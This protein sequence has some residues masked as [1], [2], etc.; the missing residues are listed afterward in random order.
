ND[1]K[2]KVSAIKNIPD[3]NIKLITISAKNKN[4]LKR[5]IV[6]L[7]NLSKKIDCSQLEN[8]SNSETRNGKQEWRASFT[9][10]HPGELE[11]QSS[12]LIKKLKENY[13]FD[14]S[15]SSGFSEIKI[16]SEEKA[17]IMFPGQGSQY[18]GMA[19]SLLEAFPEL[20]EYA[21]KLN[22]SIKEIIPEGVLHLIS[23]HGWKKSDEELSKLQ[24]EITQTKYAQPSI[25]LASLLVIKLLKKY[26]LKNIIALGHSLGE[27]S[28]MCFSG[29]IS[30]IDAV[31][32]SAIRGKLMSERAGEPGMMAAIF[33]N[34]YLIKEIIVENKCD[35]VIANYNSDNQSVI[36]GSTDEI[37]NA[38]DIFKKLNVN[39]AELSVSHAFHSPIVAKISDKFLQNLSLFKFNTKPAIT[40]YS[41]VTGNIFSNR[42]KIDNYLGNQI[43]APVNF[44]D[45]IRNIFQE[46]K[47]RTVVECGPK[48]ILTNLLRDI[49][50]SSE[51]TPHATLT[52]DMNTGKSI[53]SA[54]SSL[55]I[56]GCID[57]SFSKNIKKT[58]FFYDHTFI[59]N[60]LE[61]KIQ[62]SSEENLIV[63]IAETE[64][65][66]YNFAVDWLIKKT[67]FKKNKLNLDL[68]LKED[69]NLDSLKLAELIF[70]LG[71]KFRPGEIIGN[72]SIFSNSSI[73][74]LVDAFRKDNIDQ[75]DQTKLRNQKKT[76]ISHPELIPDWIKTFKMGMV[77]SPLLIKM[78]GDDFIAPVSICGE[79]NRFTDNLKNIFNETLFIKNIADHDFQHNKNIICFLPCEPSISL[80]NIC[81]YEKNISG[82]LFLTCKHIFRSKTTFMEKF[83]ITFVS[84]HNNFT[85]NIVHPGSSFLKSLNLEY[86]GGKF[87]WLS[88]PDNLGKTSTCLIIKNEIAANDNRV[89][90]IYDEQFKRYCWLA[91]EIDSTKKEISIQKKQK[92]VVLVTGGAK[93]I[94]F[95]L[96]FELSKSTGCTL[97]ILG[98]TSAENIYENKEIK[99][100]FKK[101]EGSGIRF[102]YYSCDLSIKNNILKTIPKIQ[103]EIGEITGILHGSGISR[104]SLFSNMDKNDYNKCLDIKVRGF[105]NILELCDIQKIK[106]IHLISSILAKTGMRMQADYCYANGWLDTIG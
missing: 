56:A 81:D 67:G 71:N 31:K 85:K 16:S 93:G 37:R 1:T 98:S 50:L 4:E 29:I 96:A 94:T 53:M 49:T 105:L 69:L 14:R 20:L 35:V 40:L 5:K 65:T 26:N 10:E 36:S 30:D 64:T 59:T 13:F 92:D 11:T 15:D 76:S 88:F 3:Y 70:L 41:T 68:K 78:T 86:G 103:A 12:M 62:G 2:E 7:N 6:E 23:E 39:C 60:P 47:I 28:A 90:A 79:Y 82:F 89:F 83:S 100:N 75:F 17:L 66:P 74:Q 33:T 24:K 73:K 42:I 102:Y 52:P 54:L 95:E 72:P 48:T 18:F 32:I 106:F 43:K 61:E 91:N 101:L 8:L 38:V 87:K 27:I 57:P 80:K 34:H 63:P 97:A 44:A 22:D 45:T 104:Y 9:V 19:A 99:T 21:E 77:E 25:V 55:Y 51:V 58:D 46:N 84:F